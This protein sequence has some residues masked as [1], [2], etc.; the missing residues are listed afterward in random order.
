MARDHISRRVLHSVVLTVALSI[1]PA[2]GSR[3]PDTSP[4]PRAFEG[5][6]VALD[7]E[8]KSLE[9]LF[10]AR[11]PGVIATRTDGGGLKLRIRGGA[12]TFYGSDEPLILLDGTP[13]PQNSNGT[14]FINPNDI[15]RIEVLKNPQDTAMYGL[16]GG[17]GVIKITTK[18][19]GRR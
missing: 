4:D 15:E 2:C 18:R 3:S 12:N 11:F 13:L 7:T 10:T 8:G 9:Q 5:D 6:T 1:L 17:N 19:P 16:R 14:I